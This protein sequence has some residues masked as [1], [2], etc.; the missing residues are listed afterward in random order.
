MTAEA[1]IIAEDRDGNPILVVEVEVTDACQADIQAFLN[2]FIKTASTLKFAMFVDLEQIAVMKS[3]VSRRVPIRRMNP[4]SRHPR[5][6][7]SRWAAGRRRGG[8]SSTPG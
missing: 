2:R 8:T 3:E 7:S 5:G 1:D 4:W 6:G